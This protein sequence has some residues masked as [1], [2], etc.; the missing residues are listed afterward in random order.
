MVRKNKRKTSNFETHDVCLKLATYTINI[1]DNEKNFPKS[2]EALTNRMREEST[3][4]YHLV[5]VANLRN[6]KTEKDERLR[7]QKLAIEKCDELTSDIMISKGIFHVKTKRILHWKAL[8]DDAR[9]HIVAW[10]RSELK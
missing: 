6:V 2:H 7:L 10:Y 1:L 8:I 5:R 4:I 3:A 9:N